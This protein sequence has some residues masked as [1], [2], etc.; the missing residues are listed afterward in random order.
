MNSNFSDLYEKTVQNFQE[1]EVVKGKIIAIQGK[2]VIVDI[3]YKSEGL[4]FASE[5]ID[6][7]GEIEKARLQ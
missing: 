5:F 2:D 1:G 4:I 6:G 7:K 3:G